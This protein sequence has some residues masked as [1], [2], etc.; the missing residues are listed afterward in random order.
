MQ[1]LKL[2]DKRYVTMLSTIHDTSMVTK[3]RRS[4]LA[5]SRFKIQGCVDKLLSLAMGQGSGEMPLSFYTVSPQN[6]DKRW[7]INTS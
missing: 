5:P 6:Q 4:R 1:A 2:R 7:I 3:R